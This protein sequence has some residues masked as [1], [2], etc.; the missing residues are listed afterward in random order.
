MNPEPSW[1][2][3]AFAAFW[4]DRLAAR[5]DR[6]PV[7][8]IMEGRSGDPPARLGDYLGPLS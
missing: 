8:P 4:Q 1:T 6:L 2:L 5:I 3:A 7:V